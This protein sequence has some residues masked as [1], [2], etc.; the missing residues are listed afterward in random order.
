MILFVRLVERGDVKVIVRLCSPRFLLLVH[1]LVFFMTFERETL[2]GEVLPQT[3]YE[4]CYRSFTDL[5]HEE[6]L[7]CFYQ[8][9][10]PGMDMRSRQGRPISQHEVMLKMWGRPKGRAGEA[11]ELTAVFLETGGVVTPQFLGEVA[12]VIYRVAHP[13]CPPFFRKSIYWLLPRIN[14]WEGLRLCCAKYRGRLD[15]GDAPNIKDAEMGALERFFQDTSERGYCL[16]LSPGEKA[17]RI[18]SYRLWLSSHPHGQMKLMVDR[19][20]GL[21]P[22]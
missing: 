15:F 11:L 12:D 6:L 21:W 19:M 4:V 20:K 8:E 2:I 17:E 18:D 22:W 9:I 14:V 13:N 3:L 16:F 5:T 7:G 10:V 1:R